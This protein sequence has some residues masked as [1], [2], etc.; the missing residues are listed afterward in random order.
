MKKSQFYNLIGTANIFGILLSVLYYAY[1][2]VTKGEV[3]FYEPVKW[4][5]FLE[6]GLILFGLFYSMDIIIKILSKNQLSN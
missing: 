3:I 4:I 2:I 1:L 6:C 5:L